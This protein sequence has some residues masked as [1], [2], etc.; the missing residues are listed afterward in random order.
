MHGALAAGHTYRS[1]GSV[2]VT[3]IGTN[4]V[5]SLLAR[6]WAVVYGGCLPLG[7]YT[8][9]ISMALSRRISGRRFYGIVF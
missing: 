5:I 8:A 9:Y 1:P 3:H 6:I 7:A 2:F 4:P